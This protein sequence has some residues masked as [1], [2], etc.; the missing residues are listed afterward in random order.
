M[1]DLATL[2]KFIPNITNANLLKGRG[3]LRLC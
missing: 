1:G 3:S 2:Q